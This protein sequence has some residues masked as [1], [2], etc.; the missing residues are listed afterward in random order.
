MFQKLLNFLFLNILITQL[1]YLFVL[2]M[3][4]GKHSGFTFSLCWKSG[5]H[6]VKQ[7][8]DVSVRIYTSITMSESQ[9]HSPFH[10]DLSV[11][12]LMSIHSVKAAIMYHHLK[13]E[14]ELLNRQKQNFCHYF[15]FR[16]PCDSPAFQLLLSR[17][18]HCGSKPHMDVEAP[19]FW[20]L[21]VRKHVHTPIR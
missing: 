21:F 14:E 6:L 9:S 18:R 17:A 16:R 7:S 15:C 8:N 12:Y 5:S 11:N 2:S 10:I 20:T 13:S 1:S 19:S 4:I 3:K